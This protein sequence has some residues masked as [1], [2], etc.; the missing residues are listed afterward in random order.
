MSTS[1]NATPHAATA[2]RTSSAAGS[3]S[4]RSTSFNTSGP[5]RLEITTVRFRGIDTAM[6]A[7][8]GDLGESGVGERER[9]VER[10]QALV[11]LGFGDDERRRDHEVA[12]PAEA[13]DAE[14]HHLRRDLI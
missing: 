7:I 9:F 12:D 1:A 14:R 6:A 2:S 8:L 11:E 10:A 5:P 4:S 13:R 3:G